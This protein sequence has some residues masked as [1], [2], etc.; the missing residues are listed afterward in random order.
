MVTP[1]CAV[2]HLQPITGRCVRGQ[3]AGSP[4]GAH[5]YGALIDACARA[6]HAGMAARVYHKAL[7]E[8]CEGALLV[9]TSAVAACGA[10]EKGPDLPTA[11]DI[12]SDLQRCARLSWPVRL[13]WHATDI[14]YDLQRCAPVFGWRAGFGLQRT[15]IP[16]CSAR[17]RACLGR[18]PGGVSSPFK[19]VFL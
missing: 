3:A 6:G 8:R 16:T 10:A 18:R 15:L 14:C 4:A 9:Y 2:H 13:F 7:R 5:T 11:M 1:P 19:S 17:S 12:Y